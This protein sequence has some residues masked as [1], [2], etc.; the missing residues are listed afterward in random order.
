MYFCEI[1][2]KYGV[3]LR[4]FT[5]IQCRYAERRGAGEC[6]AG[7]DWW[8]RQRPRGLAWGAG[9]NA[10]LARMRNLAYTALYSCTCAET[11]GAI[12]LKYNVLGANRFAC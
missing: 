3:F 6:R 2:L 5:K 1:L 8:A 11:P 10:E 4:N 7:A 12:V 9:H